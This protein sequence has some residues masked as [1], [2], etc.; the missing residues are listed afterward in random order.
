MCMFVY[1]CLSVT[2]CGCVCVYVCVYDSVSVCVC[3]SVSLCVCVCVCLCLC[4]CGS[5]TSSLSSI[6]S[7]NKVEEHLWP[8]EY[9]SSH[10]KHSPFSLR[11]ASSSIVRRLKGTVDGF[12]RVG[13]GNN[14]V[15]VEGVG[16]GFWLKACRMARH[17][18]CRGLVWFKDKT[19][20][21]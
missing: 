13:V 14:G 1:V 21:Y 20:Y 15:V 12:V 3:V 16:V 9:F 10:W 2:L 19:L 7:R 4:L 17:D 11:I 8:R 5:G 6:M 18:T